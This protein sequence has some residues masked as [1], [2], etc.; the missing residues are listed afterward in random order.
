MTQLEKIADVLEKAAAYIDAVES[1][2][3]DLIREG[4][5]KLAGLLKEKYEAATGAP[6][7][8]T[9]IEKLASA[10]LDLLETFDRLASAHSSSEMGGPAD[11]PDS[12]RPMSVKEASEVADDRFLNFILGE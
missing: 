9:A 2:K 3:E 7:D 10:D 11:K 6:I 8:E 12:S 4:R 5:T 1:E